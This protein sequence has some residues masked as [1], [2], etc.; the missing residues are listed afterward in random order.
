MY[1]APN[2]YVVS[3]LIL[4][5]LNLQQYHHMGALGALWLAC[6]VVVMCLNVLFPVTWPPKLT[7]LEIG[8][9]ENRGPYLFCIFIQWKS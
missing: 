3:C 8:L 6:L 7:Q 4:N 1:V 2:Q 9:F 5:E